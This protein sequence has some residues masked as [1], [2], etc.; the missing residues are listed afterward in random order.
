MLKSGW[1]VVAFAVLVTFAWLNLG[2]FLDVTQEPVKSDII[3]CLGG[4]T[5]ERVQKSITLLE[6]GL[7]D[8]K[9]LLLGE[10][11]Y[12]QP[13]IRKNHPDINMLID[14]SPKNTKEEVLF[15]KTYM[16]EHGYTSALIVTDSPHA[17]RVRLL[18]SLLSTKGDEAMDFHLV[19]SGVKWWSAEHY[20]TNE[21]AV[22]AAKN[23]SLKLLYSVV[24]YGCLEKIGRLDEVE[25]WIKGS[26]K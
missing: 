18:T 7:A 8:K 3:V 24:A 25:A 26:K 4:G 22:S 1:I 9:L 11:W 21:R 13:Y 5:I 15:I 10:S 14:E 12:N 19:S 2:R 6:Q 20:Y 16:K 17:R 23:E